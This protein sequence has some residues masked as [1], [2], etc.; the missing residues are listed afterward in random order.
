M[1]LQSRTDATLSPSPRLAPNSTS[2]APPSHQDVQGNAELTAHIHPGKVEVSVLPQRNLQVSKHF[3]IPYKKKRH[4]NRRLIWET[5]ALPHPPPILLI[6]I[7]IPQRQLRKSCRGQKGKTMVT[8]LTVQSVQRDYFQVS[9]D[10][11]PNWNVENQ[12][13]ILLVQ[14]KWKTHQSTGCCFF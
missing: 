6:L 1:V 14:E 9:V 3:N 5:G 8:W 2:S 12:T 7:V 11:N 13:P 10:W 4:G